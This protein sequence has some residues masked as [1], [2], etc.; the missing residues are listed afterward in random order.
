M[1]KLT[2]IKIK[3]ED[4]TYSD[5]IP[6]SVL[7]NNVEWNNN[8]SL[9]DVLGSIA[10]DTKGSVQSQLTQLFNEKI[11]ST[12]LD[13]YVD[14]TLKNEVTSWLNTYI[15]PATG[16]IAYD[17]SLSIEG[18]A[19]DAK[20]AGQIV[21]ISA[22]KPTKQNNRI[23]V[24]AAE[25]EYEVPTMD[26]IENLITSEYDATKTYKIN[27]FV[28][29]NGILYYCNT[30]ITTPEAWTASHWTESKVGDEVGAIKNDL[31]EL[32]P[33]L[34]DYAVSPNF[35]GTKANTLYR[36][37]IPSGTKITISTADGSTI[38][39][40]ITLNLYRADKTRADYWTLKNYSQRTI[41]TNADIYYLAITALWS[42][43]IQVEIGESKTPYKTYF[44]NAR[45]LN[46]AVAQLY[47]SDDIMSLAEKAK[48]VFPLQGELVANAYLGSLN[49]DIVSVNGYY[50]YI[51]NYI[52]VYPNEKYIYTGHAG[53]SIACVAYYDGD[54]SFISSEAGHSPVDIETRIFTVPS[55]A[56]FARFCS[57]HNDSTVSDLL[58]RKQANEFY[59]NGLT[60][61]K[62]YACGDSF[63]E[64]AYNGAADRF[65]TEG[66]Y[67]NKLKCYPYFIGNR[68]DC[69]VHNIS[70]SGS[71]LAY[72]SSEPVNYSFSYDYGSSDPSYNNY[73]A[74]PSD[75]KYITLW[76]GVN[77]SAFSVPIGNDDDNVNTTFKGAWN[78]VLEYF[79]TN[80]PT[81]KIGIIV[82]NHLAQAYVNATI[83]MAKRWGIPFLDLNSD[84]V[85]MMQDTLSD[86]CEEAKQ[87]AIDKFAISSTNMHPNYYAHEFESRFIEQW[88][89]SL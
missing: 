37:Y 30:A 3:Y 4:G 40:A 75:A 20:A 78:I 10:F 88:M 14:L 49:G 27:D 67:A 46:D 18:A 54:F 31:S 35:L 41:T 32:K 64:G 19:A 71:T 80:C 82:S 62:W 76:F 42:A 56:V 6:I 57:Y 87:I 79:L 68:T 39:D 29:H 22:T 25:Q 13:N 36:C 5:Q 70:L 77:D 11:D 17:A 33:A 52:R 12:E 47:L 44:M 9:V 23:W 86:A 73:K 65:I 15:A 66:L 1:D 60:H 26:D 45:V 63:T 48:S 7:A 72:V 16:T 59:V 69:D 38:T 8:Y 51:T 53:P 61:K 89:L 43:N 28:I 21:Q 34:S 85:P 74:V 2:A 81:A 83:D 55:G 50:S 58:V 84:N 24:A